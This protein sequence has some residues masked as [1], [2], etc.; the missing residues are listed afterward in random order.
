MK[1]KKSLS[2]EEAEV[3]E[4]MTTINNEVPTN[5]VQDEQQVATTEDANKTKVADSNF[6]TKRTK[7]RGSEVKQQVISDIL[8]GSSNSAGIGV[9]AAGRS[10]SG[11]GGGIL[12]ANNSTPQADKS[13]SGSRVGKKLDRV[14][15]KLNYTPSE[16]VLLEVD[17]SK[18]LSAAASDDQGYNGTYRNE[19]ARSQK[20]MG[21]VPADLMYQRSVDLILN[22]KLYW[23]EGQ[24]C[25]QGSDNSLRYT[26]TSTVRFDELTGEKYDKDVTYNLGNFLH[27][28]LHFGLS[29][30]G[31][32]IYFYAD[33]VDISANDL[34]AEDMNVASAHKLIKSNVAELD[35][36]SM[37]SKAGDEKADIWTPLARAINEPTRAA[38]L[39]SSIEAITGAYVY[40]A[41]SKATTNMS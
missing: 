30:T 39:M 33:V 31:Q 22:D 18:P 7:G 29:A 14:A 24:M 23:I 3:K 26:P 40:L 20:I 2:R 21:A 11:T 9:N 4:G 6:R 12:G 16:Q 25:L 17:E 8:T 32:V 1:Q 34:D 35:R 19:F 5:R 27:R 13:R 28:N 38:F 10:V 37:D 41:Y 36:M 15:T